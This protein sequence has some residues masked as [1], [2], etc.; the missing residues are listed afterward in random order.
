MKR[1]VETSIRIGT[2]GVCLWGNNVQVYIT[3]YR[4]YAVE[5]WHSSRYIPSDTTNHTALEHIPPPLLSFY[6]VRVRLAQ[7]ATVSG[8]EQAMW[9][10][11]CAFVCGGSQ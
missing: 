10:R 3:K 6:S 1:N 5:I 11:H 2:G 4:L 7:K 9:R 8:C